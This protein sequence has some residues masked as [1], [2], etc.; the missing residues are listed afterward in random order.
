M[1]QI[2]TGMG[3]ACTETQTLTSASAFVLASKT[4]AVV[5]VSK[6]QT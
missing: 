5:I 2:A 3:T 4:D 6:I 1:M